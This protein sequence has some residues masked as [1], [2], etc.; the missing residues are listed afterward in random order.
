MLTI[1]KSEAKQIIERNVAFAMGAGILPIPILDFGALATIQIKMV[2]NLA[3]EYNIQPDEK[4]LRRIILLLLKSPGISTWIVG[5]LCSFS[6]VIPG[7]G[8]AIGGGTM[9][10]LIGALT[11]ATGRVFAL[12]FEKKGSLQDFDL[13]SQSRI[14]R[15]EFNAGKSAVKK[16]NIRKE[17]EPQKPEDRFKDI[18]L[19]LIL[20]P[21]LGPNG[22][23]YVKT[24]LMGKHLEKYLGTMKSFEE[25][26]QVDDLKLV[27]D[28][29]IEDSRPAFVEYLIEK[30]PP[31]ERT[32]S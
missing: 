1:K 10:I 5:G 31:S 17:N 22:K 6:K 30:L 20:K 28:R 13:K 18:N 2:Q 14:F 8:S 12:H 25:K 19:Y 32:V 26:Y 3:R 23:V 4:E 15:R 16:I 21:K 24:Y 29:I 9:A 11:Y 7:L 27:E